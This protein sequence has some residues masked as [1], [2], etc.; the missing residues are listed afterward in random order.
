MRRIGFIA[1]TLCAFFIL[2]GLGITTS[3]KQFNQLVVPEQP[4]RIYD[5]VYKEPEVLQ[6]ELLGE[7]CSVNVATIKQQV[8]IG[9]EQV[10]KKWQECKDDPQLHQQVESA[11]ALVKRQWQALVRTEEVR[12]VNQWVKERL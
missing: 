1:I 12:A 10:K 11:T 4:L 5:V 7:K 2:I 6:I 9:K 8:A 3:I